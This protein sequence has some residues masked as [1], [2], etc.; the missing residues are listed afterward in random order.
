[1][2][3]NDPYSKSKGLCLHIWI[4]SGGHI[5]AFGVRL[6]PGACAMAA[7]RGLEAEVAAETLNPGSCTN[8]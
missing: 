3:Y 6:K 2:I 1:M 4:D 7:R 5:S 8:L